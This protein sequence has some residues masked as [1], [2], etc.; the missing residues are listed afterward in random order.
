MMKEKKTLLWVA[1]L[2]AGYLL[3]SI[4]LACFWL[5]RSGS[6][7]TALQFL[8]VVPLVSYA[9]LWVVGFIPIWVPAVVV[10]LPFITG[11]IA[12]RKTWGKIVACCA[13]AA[14]LL[15]SAIAPIAFYALSGVRGGM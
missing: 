11:L 14:H 9:F 10:G 15:C 3:P 8:L 2:L 7:V 12:I 1:V 4:A 5:V 13:L 6:N